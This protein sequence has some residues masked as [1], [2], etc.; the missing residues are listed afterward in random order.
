MD[1]RQFKR[2]AMRRGNFI[3]N[4]P[5]AMAYW[6]TCWGLGYHDRLWAYKSYKVGNMCYQSGPVM[7]RHGHYTNTICT[8][9]GEAV[10]EYRF[11][12]ALATFH[13]PEL[14]PEERAYID[15]QNARE[16]AELAR[17]KARRARRQA[18]TANNVCELS[19]AF[20]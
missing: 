5:A 13:A 18:P 11:K 3:D 17:L 19:F 8:I 16:A 7:L 10:S 9:D 20:A 14:T 15:S 6:A 2:E 12:K 1:L 4:K